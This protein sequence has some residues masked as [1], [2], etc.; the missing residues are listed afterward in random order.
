MHGSK[1]FVG[2]LS[3]S[4]TQEQ[5]KELFS[6]HGTVVDIRIIGDKGFGFIEMSSQA[7]AENAKN[8]LDGFNFDGRNMRVDEARARGDKK[9][10]GGRRY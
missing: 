5:L 2:N 8:A 6:Q 1:L 10:G 4:V 3:Y 7:E 9:G